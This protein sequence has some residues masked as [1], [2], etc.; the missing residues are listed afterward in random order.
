MRCAGGVAAGDEVLELPL[1]VGEQRARAEAEQ[2][3]RAASDRPALPSSDT[4]TRATFFAVRIPPAG[5]NP[6]A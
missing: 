4:G 3:R 1:D 2:I 5:L 6:T